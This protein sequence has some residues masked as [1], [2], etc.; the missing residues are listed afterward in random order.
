MP[1][2][3]RIAHDAQEPNVVVRP[4]AHQQAPAALLRLQATAGN[5]AVSRALRGAA[6]GP[7]RASRS[8]APTAADV[9]LLAGLRACR[10]TLQRS[11]VAT[12]GG[13]WETFQ[14]APR[15]DFNE[16]L[17]RVPEAQGTR[18]VD[19]MLRF[20][21]N[22]SVDAELIG[23]TQ[24][25]QSV[26]AGAPMVK[27]KQAARSIPAADAKP[28]DTGPGET[29]EGTHIDQSALGNNPIYAV[30][31]D[32]DSLAA[33]A[34][35]ANGQHGWHYK[36]AAGQPKTQE[37]ELVDTPRRDGAQTDSH[38]VFETTALATKGAQLGTYYGSIR[39]GWRTDAAGNLTTIPLEKVSDGVPSSTFLKAAGLWNQGAS[40]SGAANID[41]P[42][43]DVKV[44]TAPITVQPPAPAPA[45][46]LPAATRLQVISGFLGPRTVK[47]VDGPHTGLTGEIHGADRS[48][49]EDERR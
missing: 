3:R 43:P 19:I 6:A 28:I 26:V 16:Q 18:G 1:G 9:E 15:K 17:D 48:R 36:D 44:T 37:A 49:L 2:M 31:G 13:D 32:T 24:S 23:L 46:E 21:P 47:V 4:A 5:Q 10:A 20:T 30:D 40:E 41:L 7:R 14:Y 35:A 12:S 25:A 39:W 29:D 8:A 11:P 42:L 27:P 22:D 33:D 45:V 34:T 38:Q